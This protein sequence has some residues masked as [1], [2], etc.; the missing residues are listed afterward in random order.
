[1]SLLNDLLN[2][3]KKVEA[4]QKKI[5]ALRTDLD[6][7]KELL[8]KQIEYD[9]HSKYFEDVGDLLKK[10]RISNPTRKPSDFTVDQLKFEIIK[11]EDNLYDEESKMK[12][13]AK[14]LRE[15]Y[16]S[17]KKE[18]V[19]LFYAPN[20]TPAP[21]DDLPNNYTAC[22]V[23]V[24][25][26]PAH[27][28]IEDGT[29]DLDVPFFLN[30]REN[31]NL[32]IDID[33]RET[34]ERNSGLEDIIA[35]T[36][37]HYF[38]SFPSKTLR[39]G[40]YSPNLTSFAKLNSISSA[41]IKNKV[42]LSPEACRTREQLSLMLANVTQKA[43]MINGKLL[44]NNC[45]DLYDLYANDVKTEEFQLLIIH[46][47]IRELTETNLNAL[48]GLL[49]SC[50]SYGV[51]IV[52]IDDFDPSHYQNKTPQF[53]NLIE[54]IKESGTLFRFEPH[55]DEHAS[56]CP[57]IPD[58]LFVNFPS[59]FDM[60][61]QSIYQFIN[62]HLAVAAKAKPKFISFEKIGFGVEDSPKDKFESISV[63]V[64]LADNESYSLTFDI[65]GSSPNANMV[66]GIPGTGKSTLIDAL[67]MNG[68]MK[69]SPDELV[70]QL[71]D[72]KDG[73][74][75]SVYTMPDC[76]IPHVK[77]VSQNNKPEEADIILSNILLES[78]RRNKEFVA[79]RNETG[80]AIRN[81]AEYNR[82]VATGRFPTRKNMPRLIV[83]IDECQY[84][85]EEDSLSEKAQNIIRKC[86]SQGIHLILATQTLSHKMRGTTK[87]VE[88]IYAFEVAKE[89][90]DQLLSRKYASIV[91]TEVP[92]G[93]FMC[94]ASNNG[95][96]DCT[97]IKIAYDG[98]ETARYSAAIRNKFS[99]YPV[100]TVIIGD[101]S[102]KAITM[103]QF[104][105]IYNSLE[106]FELPLGEN[107]VDHQ[108]TTIPYD[109]HRPM[110]MMGSHQE[111]SDEIL[112]VFSLVAIKRNI[113]SFVVDAS[114]KQELSSFIQ[115]HDANKVISLTDE[116]GYLQ[117]L[118][119][120]YK[121]YREREGNLR[122]E[123]APVFFFINSMQT[124]V[125]FLNNKK[126]QEATEAAPQA[127]AANNDFA[128]MLAALKNQGARSQGA[129]EVNGKETLIPFLFSN[130]H[131]VNIFIVASL[132]SLNATNDNG[133]QAFGFNHKN[134]IRT[135]DYKLLYPNCNNDVRSI[136][137]DAFR[138]KLLNG[139]TPDMALLSYEQREYYKIRYFQLDEE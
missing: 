116:K 119:D 87:F 65:A 46:D 98:G 53:L 57:R 74:S 81:I 24:P 75:S 52:L 89:D 71:L 70:F 106:Q 66:V 7:T 136:M 109:K 18:C 37:L 76:Q 64:A 121:I 54:R 22:N 72:F 132:D 35:G 50:H 13:G 31:G 12:E 30:L 68:A 5:D 110:F 33:N 15:A 69:Y 8:R 55:Q 108:T 80:E 25:R 101:K 124:I 39:V 21:C 102:R 100:D 112:K 14:S 1:M 56:Y 84:L 3:P 34:Y 99:S 129:T 6:D 127:A 36:A 43:D 49:S 10:F 23:R 62:T 51:R 42:S 32:L 77:V 120:V 130:A 11:K 95:G 91:S 19:D 133:E 86:R 113:K 93:S 137:E 90:A 105:E 85:F 111:A 9:L 61:A 29:R 131:K 47:A 79:L 28:Y 41:L 17:S 94:F 107:Y 82:L 20:A 27:K 38:E 125:D 67:I 135:C 114:Q 88:G 2:Y 126:Y 92:K 26:E 16:L 45:S 117:A 60:S 139:L 122:E 134:V 115:K 63:P 123:Y 128:S 96:Q 83:V 73:I 48:H 44:E 58:G 40:I 104:E 118:L 59:C 103:P 138:E 78:E 97:K 4:E